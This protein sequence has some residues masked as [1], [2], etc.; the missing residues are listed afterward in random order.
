LSLQ[1]NSSC[2][3]DPGASGPE[4]APVRLAVVARVRFYRDGLAA[5]FRDLTDFTVIA[6]AAAPADALACVR[7]HRPEIVLLGIG[8]GT[9]VGLVQDILDE[10]PETRVVA[11]D[12]AD[13]D[14]EVLPLAEAGVAGY[15]TIDASADEVVSVVE[16]VAHGDALCSPRIAALLLRRVAVLSAPRA[17]PAGRLGALTPREREIVALIGDGRSNKEIARSL[18][19]EVATVKN[20]VH[21]IL[22][23]LQV[24][25]RGEA[26]ALLRR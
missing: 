12:I 18:C 11:L 26:A 24:T 19:I 17:A 13:D 20:H 2:G 21:N 14:P 9:G 6:T 23:K 25:R 10:A 15:V 5:L 3:P 22:E 7:A 16:S 8:P 1:E 4:R